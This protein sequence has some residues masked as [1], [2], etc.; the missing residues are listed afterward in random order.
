MNLDKE[1]L[2]KHTY[3]HLINN[4]ICKKKTTNNIQS[5]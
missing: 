1:N 2:R 5:F 4:N 3:Q